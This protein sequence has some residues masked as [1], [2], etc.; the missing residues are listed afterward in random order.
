[1]QD[2]LPT[3]YAAAYLILKKA[4]TILLIHRKHTGWMDDHWGL[5]QGHI[6][7]TE[8]VKQAA[9]REA[10]EEVGIDLAESEVEL[11]HVMHRPSSDRVYFDFFFTADAGDRKVHNTEPDKHDELK[12]FKITELPDNTI[13]YIKRVP[14]YIKTGQV[15]S[16]DRT[17]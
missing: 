10:K 5:P 8:S 2:R 16:E 17:T 13:P 4:D 1:M 6:E 9:L 7:G 15:F 12:W 3:F 11:C 14:E